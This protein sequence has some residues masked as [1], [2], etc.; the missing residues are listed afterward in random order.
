MLSQDYS[1][2]SFNL[3]FS[4]GLLHE[5]EDTKQV[6]SEILRV[7]KPGGKV[8]VSDLRRDLYQF[9]LGIFNDPA[10]QKWFQI[11]VHAACTND[12]LGKL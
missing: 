2:F 11:S 4:N 1:S 8:R 7:L 12:E 10:I 5:W 6:F 3:A 9:M